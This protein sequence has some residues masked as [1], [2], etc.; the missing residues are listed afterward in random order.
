MLYH[1]LAVDYD[2][3]LATNGLVDD[4]TLEALSRLRQSGR[5]IVLVTGRLLGPLLEAFPQVGLCDLV[6]AENG[7]LLYDPE[8]RTERPLADPPPREFV[9]KLTERGVPIH[10]AG[11]VII[12]TCIPYERL[13]W[14][15]SATCRWNC[16]S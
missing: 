3:T 7:A 9:E 5:R 8:T 2:G 1:A 15:R 13:F 14:K 4:A 11:R 10:E 12:A 16:K 6:V